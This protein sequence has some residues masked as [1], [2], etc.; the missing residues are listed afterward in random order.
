MCTHDDPT[1]D[2]TGL[3]RG[4]QV[5][6]DVPVDLRRGRYPDGHAFVELVE[7]LLA[8]READADHGD[9]GRVVHG[10][11][12]GERL[13]PSL[14][15]LVEDDHRVVAGGLSVLRLD[16]E[17]AG[18]ALDQRPAAGSRMPGQ[19]PGPQLLLDVPPPPAG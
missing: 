6:R 5:G 10:Q 7:E 14:L 15:T 12:A 4:Q 17:V 11:G 1:V 19:S 13:L 2:A 18:T 8:E 3:G 9:R 16:E